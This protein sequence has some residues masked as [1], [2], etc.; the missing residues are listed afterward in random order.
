MVLGTGRCVPSRG[1]LNSGTWVRHLQLV[2]LRFDALTR[3]LVQIGIVDQYGSEERK[4]ELSLKDAVSTGLEYILLQ[5]HADFA[6]AEH[7]M[8]SAGLPRSESIQ[9]GRV[10]PLSMIGN[11]LLDLR[12]KGIHVDTDLI[13]GIAREVKRE[14]DSGPHKYFP[15]MHELPPDLD[16]L[17]EVIQFLARSDSLEL[18]YPH[19]KNDVYLAHAPSEGGGLST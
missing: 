6:E 8:R 12:D 1:R 10:F 15:R 3:D 11:R 17:A 16:D 4:G 5:F 18:C 14:N 2:I 19:W 9:I 13:A 7:F